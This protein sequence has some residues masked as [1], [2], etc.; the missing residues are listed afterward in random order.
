MDWSF[1]TYV[2][3]QEMIVYINVILYINVIVYI[4]VIW[5]N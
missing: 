2:I 3:D 4:N 5:L 1:H